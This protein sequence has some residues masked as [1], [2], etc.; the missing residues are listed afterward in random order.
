[1]FYFPHGIQTD[2]FRLLQLMEKLKLLRVQ[3][4]TN[5]YPS[6]IP[7][8][9]GAIATKVGKEHDLFHN[10]LSDTEYAYR[11]PLIQYKCIGKQPAIL[12]LGEGVEEI[13]KFF[14]KRNW[15]ILIGE[16]AIAMKIAK[17][18]LNQ[19]TMNVWDKT[20]S[21]H[22]HHYIALNQEAYKEYQTF[23]GLGD[24]ISY[25]ERKLITHILIFLEGIGVIADK[26]I[27]VKITDMPDPKPVRY[28]QQ[29]LMGFDL[30]FC[31]NVFL[32]N[33]IG[34]GGKVAVGF[35]TVRKAP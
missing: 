28:K 21:Y 5:L 20:F 15:D 30:D 25:L 13:H 7:A 3:F 34:L 2:V 22:I 24:R 32:P 19:F 31:T 8:F 6:E 11:Y 23:A 9:R 29:K 16:R 26:T 35:G 17:L 12:C 14:E 27:T 4:D 1:M 10:H 33:H 18:D